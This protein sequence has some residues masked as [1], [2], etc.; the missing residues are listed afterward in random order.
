MCLIVLFTVGLRGLCSALHD[1]GSVLF[2]LQYLTNYDVCSILLGT[3][4]ML[5][6][7][8]VIRYLGFFKKYNVRAVP[9]LL[10]VFMHRPTFPAF[11]ENLY[12]FPDINLNP[13]GGVPECDPILLLRRHDLPRLL[14]LRLDRPWAS[15]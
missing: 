4:T 8:G 15:S 9:T 3:A 12:S 6:W 13:E 11:P 2:L 7:V 10:L 14:F 5:V 1:H